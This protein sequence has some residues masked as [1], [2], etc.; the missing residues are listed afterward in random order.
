M[1]VEEFKEV[2]K[3]KKNT[4]DIFVIRKN[5]KI[6]HCTDLYLRNNNLV[7][8]LTTSDDKLLYPTSHIEIFSTHIKNDYDVLFTENEEEIENITLNDI[9]FEENI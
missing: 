2:F 9:S 6:Y 8:E 4:N 7:F 3:N 5:H 1:K